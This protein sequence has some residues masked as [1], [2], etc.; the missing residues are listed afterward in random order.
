MVVVADDPER[1]CF[2]FLD[3]FFFFLEATEL[4][5]AAAAAASIAGGEF[6]AYVRKAGNFGEGS[7][8]GRLGLLKVTKS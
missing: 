4:P 2:F 8:D 3:L 1:G 5:V 7:N 6:G